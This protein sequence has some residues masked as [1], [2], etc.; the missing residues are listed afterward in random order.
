MLK[1]FLKRAA[2]P[3]DL[4]GLPPRPEQLGLSQ[5]GRDCLK[6]DLERLIKTSGLPTG[7][8][9][10]ARVLVV[11]G[12]DDAIVAPAA[13][14]EHLLALTSHLQEA[15]EQWQLQDVGHALLVPDLLVRVQQW[16]DH[17]SRAS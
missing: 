12:M 10:T 13:S 11:D 9:K 17:N 7:L 16:L 14:R 8:P 4:G 5:R 15:P 1:T 2:Q 3:A 6:D